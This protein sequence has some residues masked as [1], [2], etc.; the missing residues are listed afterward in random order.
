[1]T[2]TSIDRLTASAIRTWGRTGV[3]SWAVDAATYRLGERLARRA[4]GT[5]VRA[6]LTAGPVALGHLE[7]PDYRRTWI[8]G[9]YEPELAAL[10]ADIVRPGDIAIDVGAN[11]GLHAIVLAAHVGPRGVV[12][13]FEPLPAAADVLQ[14]SIDANAFGDRLRLHRVALSDAPGE[15][16]LWIGEGG[17]VTSSLIPNRWL[18]GEV[19]VPVSTLD[20]V[21]LQRLDRAPRLVKIDV[22]G[23]EPDVLRGARKL[24]ERFPP[25]YLVLE[26][27]SAT[28][29]EPVLERLHGYEPIAPLALPPR[30]TAAPG[31]PGFAFV[32]VVF[33]RSGS[34]RRP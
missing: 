8:R 34:G 21:L 26:F 2:T 28:A 4:A 16:T 32:N 10:F 12:H 19:T 17:G 25:E 24:F 6:S 18:A 15:L 13:A 1:M 29:P 3:A 9:V 33:R 11:I 22:E 5:L 7:H 30:S 31:E 14:A 20:D 27:T 23:K